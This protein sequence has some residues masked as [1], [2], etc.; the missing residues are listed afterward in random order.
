MGGFLEGGFEETSS[1]ADVGNANLF[2]DFG[3]LL[4][5]ERREDFG[6]LHDLGVEHRLPAA[7]G[8]EHGDGSEGNAVPRQRQFHSFASL[9][10]CENVIHK[11]DLAACQADSEPLSRDLKRGGAGHLGDVT[12]PVFS[13]LL[14]NHRSVILLHQD[15][16]AKISLQTASEH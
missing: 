11:H 10:R 13:L 6:E 14:S 7:G 9:P 15:F 2:F 4:A 16:A 12:P 5:A 1:A 8:T 3:P